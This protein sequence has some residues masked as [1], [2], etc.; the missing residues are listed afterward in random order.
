MDDK[1]KPLEL[2]EGLS[3]T[4]NPN[5]YPQVHL[6]EGASAEIA[7]LAGFLNGDGKHAD[8]V[9]Q[10]LEA[11]ERGDEKPLTANE[12]SVT[13]NG[14]EVEIEHLWLSGNPKHKYDKNMLV[15]LL[16]HWLSLFPASH[17]G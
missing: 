14:A 13:V 17:L 1:K 5:G 3:F 6:A 4:P 16:R 10:I 11:A 12:Y 2:P 9:K 7:F 15:P 8:Y